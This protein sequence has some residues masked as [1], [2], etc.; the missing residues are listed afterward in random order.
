MV[1]SAHQQDLL[2]T[3]EMQVVHSLFRRELRLAGSLVRRVHPGDVGRA[4]TVADHLDLVGRLLHEHHTLEDELLWP[5]LLERVPVE[6]APIVHLMESQHQEVDAAL[7]RIA[8][9]LPRWRDHAAAVDRDELAGLYEDLYLPLVEHLDAEE[10]RLLPLVARSI[11]EVE[12]HELG[13]RA[14]RE[15]RRREAMLVFGMLQHD[16]DPAVVRGMLASA[17]PP[18]RALV[19]RLAR[20]SF[21]RH[22]VRVHGTATP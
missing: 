6:L 17:P 13:D 4:R 16:G 22:S 12:W 19:P 20:R 18:V 3:R 2:D 10:E 14:R 7:R 21:R 8:T 5:R 1:T 11:T 15:G 9:V